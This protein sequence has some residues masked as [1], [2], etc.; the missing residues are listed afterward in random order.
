MESVILD[1]GLRVIFL[2]QPS[3]TVTIEVNVK[4]G[5]NNEKKS[6]QGISHFIEHLLFEGTKNRP[7]SFK[8]SNE[9]EKLGGE[10]NAATSNERTFYFVKVLNKH[11][12]IALSII[13]DII[14]NPLFRED[15][16]EKEKH[17]VIDEIK[18]VNDQPRFYQWVFF[19]STLY[20]K[21]PA[22]N[23]IYGKISTVQNTDRSMI[24][25]YYQRHYLPNNMTVVVVG[26]VDDVFSKVTDAF[27]GLKKNELAQLS[28]ENEPRQPA[29][30]VKMVKRD[31]I[32]AY[33][34]LGYRSALRREQDSYVLDVIRAILGRG[35]SGKIFNEIRTKR[36]LAYD[37]G[38]L[39]NPSTNFGY[40]AVYI[41]TGKD[42][43]VKVRDLVLVELEKITNISD[44]ELK[45]AKT[46][47]EG[48]HLMQTEDT[49]KMADI[50][51]SWDQ[52]GDFA[53]VDSYVKNIKAVTREDITRVA[54]KY[55][56]NYTMT[57]IH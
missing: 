5:S 48:E 30:I 31:T 3:N 17:V 18:L 45:E 25:D 6:Q 21:H 56:K 9:I 1:N 12:D 28:I 43:I 50:L 49:Q 15:V 4:V 42:K 32:Q 27:S 20:K 40:F 16:I 24:L 26:D 55:F 41:N 7:D 47:L 29:P 52:A 35:Q 57:V 34:I 14:Q 46:F 38:V 11:F 23:P 22:K 51:A 36:G 13:S 19:Q 53:L 39:H 44:L 37:V 8:I 33:L 10:L 2:R 54:E